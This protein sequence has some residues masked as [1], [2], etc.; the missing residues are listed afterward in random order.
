MSAD[1]L[2]P[3][4]RQY[5]IDAIA[6]HPER[7]A[8]V[9]AQIGVCRPYITRVLSGSIPIPSPRFIRKVAAAYQRVPCPYLQRPIEPEQCRAHAARSYAQCSQFEVMHWK[10]CRRCPVKA[11]PAT[12][13]TTT[14][15]TTTPEPA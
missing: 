6:A 5:L 4:W 13:A 14:T 10:A 3:G 9:A 8:G 1:D 7:Q 12:T 15:A 11:A 2:F